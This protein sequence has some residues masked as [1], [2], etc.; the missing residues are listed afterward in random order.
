VTAVSTGE[1]IRLS[2]L[3]SLPAVDCL[4]LV[5]TALEELA[6]AQAL[7]LI[8]GQERGFSRYIEAGGHVRFDAEGDP[9]I[10]RPGKS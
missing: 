7:A 2:D 1:W 4:D 10:W 5:A 8:H 3:T 9:I 6:I